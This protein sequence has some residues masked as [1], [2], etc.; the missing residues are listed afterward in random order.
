MTTGSRS[1]SSPEFPDEPSGQPLSPSSEGSPIRRAMKPVPLVAR[2]LWFAPLLLLAL[3][4]YLLLSARALKETYDDGFPTTAEVVDWE[5]VDRAEATYTHLVLRADLPDGGQIERTVPL[6]ITMLKFMVKNDSLDV[7]RRLPVRVLPGAEREIVLVDRAQ[8][9]QRLPLV[10]S[11]VAFSG[12]LALA[13][14]V[15]AWNR[16]LARHGDPAYRDPEDVA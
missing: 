9:Q 8:A 1:F 6:P 11:L 2:L 16:Y 5:V 12:C 14:G 3:T 7:G 15:G 13:F 4:I 10:L